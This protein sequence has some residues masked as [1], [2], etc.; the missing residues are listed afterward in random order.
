MKRETFNI[1]QTTGK[2]LQKQGYIFQLPY[3]KRA[4]FA[5]TKEGNTINS[6]LRWVVSE[7]STGFAVAFGKWD[8]TRKDTIARAEK[9]LKQVGAK[10]LYQQV[11]EIVA[12]H[13][14]AN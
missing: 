4:L 6:S 13:G 2:L 1:R 7:T 10:K 9:I 14:A 3:P 12:E 5:V 8:G 11:A